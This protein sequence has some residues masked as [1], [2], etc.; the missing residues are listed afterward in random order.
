ML[1]D[2]IKAKG[3]KSVRSRVANIA[4]FLADEY[5]GMDAVRFYGVHAG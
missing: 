5:R 1:T 4:D 3:I 2:K